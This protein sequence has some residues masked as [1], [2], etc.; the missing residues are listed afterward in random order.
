MA[1]AGEVIGL[2]SVDILRGGAQGIARYG[3]TVIFAHGNEPV[4]K[5]IN[6]TSRGTRGKVRCA[7]QAAICAV[8]VGRALCAASIVPFFVQSGDGSMVD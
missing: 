8:G 5:V 7:R 2:V 1:H 4:G 3:C 6:I